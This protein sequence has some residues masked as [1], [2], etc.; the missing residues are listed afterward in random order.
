MR[1]LPKEL[2]PATAPSSVPPLQVWRDADFLVTLYPTPQV[3][4][5]VYRLT[6][7]RAAGVAMDGR[8]RV[9]YRDG[10]TWDDLMQVKRDCGF[11]NCW[12]VEVYPADEDVVNVANMRHL[13]ILNE[14]PAFAWRKAAA[15]GQVTP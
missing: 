12:A 9:V 6:V 14:A 3:C 4:G 8:G 7:V 13:W 15:A 5:A 1:V 11:A 2:W 10:I